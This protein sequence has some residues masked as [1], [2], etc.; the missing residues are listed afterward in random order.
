MRFR[1]VVGAVVGILCTL[2]LVASDGGV[3]GADGTH[4]AVSATIRSGS[5]TTLTCQIF[6]PWNIY[7]T[8]FVNNQLVHGTWVYATGV[9]CSGPVADFALYEQLNF[10]GS[11]VSSKFQG[12][13]GRSRSADAIQS[14]FACAVCDGTW[15]AILGQIIK[16]PPGVLF[17]ASSGCVPEGGGAYLACVETQSAKL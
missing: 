16:A 17:A 8:G 6:D 15:T 13:T 9:E 11:K 7:G 14:T 3:A 10:N 12:F 5:A 1:R 2:A 4:V